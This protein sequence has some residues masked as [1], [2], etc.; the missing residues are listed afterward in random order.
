MIAPEGREGS[1]EEAHPGTAAVVR[2]NR[3][4]SANRETEG[5]EG[6]AGPT[7]AAPVPDPEPTKAGVLDQPVAPPSPPGTPTAP[8]SSA[9]GIEAAVSP[10]PPAERPESTASEEPEPLGQP[11]RPASP[12]AAVMAVAG[13]TIDLP[14]T[15]PVVTLV[16]VGG[17]GR[18][19]RFPVG[20]AEGSAL[21]YALEGIPTPRPLTHDVV[22]EIFGHFGIDVELVRI[23]SLE[24]RTLCA[25]MVVSEGPKRYTVACR[26]SDGLAF[27]LRAPVTV[28]IMVAEDVMA[29]AG[30]PAD[31]LDTGSSDTSSSD[32]SSSETG[33]VD[34]GSSDA[35]SS[36]A[37]PSGGDSPA[38]VPG[39]AS[40]RGSDEDASPSEEAS[41]KG[42]GTPP[43][44]PQPRDTEP[45]GDPPGVGPAPLGRTLEE[46][47][48]G[49][50]DPPASPVVAG[51]A[52][53]SRAE[54]NAPN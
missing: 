5:E 14:Q 9:S 1:P 28:P 45:A 25:E 7:G 6:V 4:W 18:L 41:V 10:T 54:Q 30:E 13:V 24:G 46:D 29:V 15:F 22:A 33:T 35:R 26:P 43:A 32:T 23:T 52:S 34:P 36:D 20:L 53:E 11:P 19:L 21:A 31:D 48:T 49:R 50:E 27:A 8:P 3:R 42:E 44:F 2:E 38:G 16:E 39:S 37:G 12:P 17:S 47:P 51:A 40:E